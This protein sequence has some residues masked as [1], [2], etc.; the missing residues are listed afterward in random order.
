MSTEGIMLDRPV[1]SKF[2]SMKN[3][4]GEPLVGDEE[5][6]DKSNFQEKIYLVCY[7]TSLF[8]HNS[9]KYINY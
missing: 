3:E 2:K 6:V 4:F 9:Q 5:G 8:T 1:G 7:A